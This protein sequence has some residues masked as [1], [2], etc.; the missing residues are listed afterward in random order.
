MKT[1]VLTALYFL[2]GF[3]YILSQYYHWI[4]PAV[5]IK[6]LIIPLLMLILCA[7]ISKE[8]RRMNILIFSALIFSWAGDVALEFTGNNGSFF[9]LGLLFFLF[10]HIMYLVVFVTTPGN[11]SIL[12]NRKYLLIP[13]LLFGTALV[14]FLFNDLGEMKIP[15]ILYAAVI[16]LM[17]TGAMNRIEKVN[18]KSYLLVLAGAILFVISDSSIAINKFTIP[19]KGSPI[20]IMTT[21]IIAQYLIIQGYIFQ[22]KPA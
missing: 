17:L 22:K 15:V 21:Y 16:L 3:Q 19:F 2:T 12:S 1:K 10:A 5:L 14:V 20:V 11:N 13:V 6:A 7:N 4:I 9:I 18:R 8:N